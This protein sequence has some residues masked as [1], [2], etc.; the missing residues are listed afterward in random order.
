MAS[1]TTASVLDWTPEKFNGFKLRRLIIDGGTSALRYVLLKCHPDKCVQKILTDEKHKLDPLKIGSKSKGKKVI[2][3]SQ[4]NVLYP[5]PP[6]IPDINNFDITLLS[7]LLRNICGLTAPATGW[8]KMPNAIDNSDVA[9]IVRIKLFRNK[10][11][12][13]ITETGV[14]TPDFEYYWKE[15]SSALVS[16]G[17]DQSKIDSLKNEECGERAIERVMNEWNAMENY[18]LRIET[19]QKETQKAVEMSHRDVRVQTDSYRHARESKK[20]R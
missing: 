8:D 4:W 18:L 17:M 9:T 3:Q 11:H 5:N 7:V 19:G 20:I 1:S 12:A 6:N 15:I 13:H 10:L 14:N 2:N 16:L